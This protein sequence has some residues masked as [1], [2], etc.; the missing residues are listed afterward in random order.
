MRQR[1]GFVVFPLSKPM[2][3]ENA[4]AEGMAAS[5]GCWLEKRTCRQTDSLP[6]QARS[7]T[8]LGIQSETGNRS[9]QSTSKE[10]RR[11]KTPSCFGE[12]TESFG[13]NEIHQKSLS[14]ENSGET[15]Q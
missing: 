8:A 2:E 10:R 9:R 4:R 3:R 1:K 11:Q 15:C 5:L 7:S 12:A 13:G 6:Y 14:P